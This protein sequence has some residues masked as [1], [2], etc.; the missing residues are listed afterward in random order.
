MVEIVVPVAALWM[1]A[2]C[3]VQ[4]RRLI[5]D[6]LLYRAIVRVAA[7]D[8]ESARLLIGKVEPRPRHLGSLAGWV[9]LVASIAV[10]ALGLFNE[11][12]ERGQMF[13]VAVVL[14][15]IGAGVLTFWWWSERAARRAAA[16][17]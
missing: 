11:G 4:L 5:T 16:E 9:C 13:Q 1:L 8:A 6:A 3:V 14:A 10:A 17:E 12:D 7:T 2:A 15:V